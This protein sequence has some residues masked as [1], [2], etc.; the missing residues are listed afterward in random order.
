MNRHNRTEIRT[1]TMAAAFALC[2]SM[3]APAATQLKAEELQQEDVLFEETEEEV[4]EDVPG[5]E[6]EA[7][8]QKSGVYVM[9]E[10]WSVDTSDST[11]TETVYRQTGLMDETQTS[12]ITCS[13]LDTNYSIGEYEQLRDMLANNQLYSHVDAQIS[14]SASYTD[15][16]DY[17]YIVT[18]DD[19]SEDYRE[20]YDYVVGDYRCFTVYIREYRQEAADLAQQSAVT[21]QETGR[22]IAESFTWTD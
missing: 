18:V 6:T 10:G 20:I 11:G 7:A 21:P 14:T 1:A 9:A 17:L 5:E 13:Y 12:T 4:T 16:R 3:A 2:I 15:A 19:A 8:E 22:K